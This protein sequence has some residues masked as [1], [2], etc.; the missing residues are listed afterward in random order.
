M[1]VHV[2]VGQ[3]GNQV[4]A[5]YWSLAAASCDVQP[6]NRSQ[7]DTGSSQQLRRGLGGPTT[8]VNAS[9][10]ALP[11][12]RHLFHPSSRVARCI[13]VD[14]EPK[15]VR[16]VCE[17]GV[18]GLANFQPAHTH[19]EQAGRG[20]NWAMGY[21]G[22]RLKAPAP[23]FTSLAVD[24]RRELVEL[25]MESLRREI[26]A[27]DCYQGSVVMHSLGGGTG[28]GL[29]CRVLESMRDTYSKAYIVTASVA[30]SWTRGDSPLQNYNAVLTLRCLQEIADA[31]IYKDN[32]ELLRTAAYWKAVAQ[33]KVGTDS[34]NQRV[35]LV[36][37]NSMAATDLAGMLFPL[38]LG[39]SSLNRPF[40]FGKLLHDVCPMP[41]TKMLDVR[42]GVWRDRAGSGVRNKL[43]SKASVAKDVFSATL[44]HAPVVP[45]AR[46][47]GLRHEH[48]ADFNTSLD[49]LEKL[50][51]QTVASFP[52]SYFTALASRTLIRGFYP[53][54]SE[55][56]HFSE[57]LGAMVETAF[58]P[59]PWLAATPQAT[60]T[61]SKPAPFPS[62]QAKASATI[63]VNNGSF[64]TS[65]KR[66]LERAQRQFHAGAYVHWYKQHGMENGDFEAAFEQCTTLING[67]ETTLR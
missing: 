6:D 62:L 12:P 50:V 15:V 37:M 3:C 42:S 35:S 1:S 4:G 7:C 39:D 41:A 38:A 5:A 30:P 52:R 51:H 17:A 57:K 16:A 23:A 47:L 29:G 46:S 60:L 26:E 61:F 59:V 11:L 63:C 28:S 14:S 19:V 54:S 36:E 44:F 65:T 20:N 10:K 31:V 22:P 64:L 32:D 27:V 33:E 49:L 56:D 8:A 58:P 2:H 21:Y 34:M 24:D 55:L 66:F 43:P 53:G 40:D 18:D 25:V 48:A 13:M 67:Y 9:K 45:Q